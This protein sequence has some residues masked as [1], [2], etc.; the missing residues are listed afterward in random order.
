M[1]IRDSY[2]GSSCNFW[3]PYDGR[4]ELIGA[5]VHLLSKGLDS[6]PMLYHAL[7]APIELDCF[8]L[9]MKAVEV[10]H[11]SLVSRIKSGELMSYDGVEQDKN[12]EM[13]YTRNIDFNDDVAREYLGNML[14]PKQVYNLLANRYMSMFTNPFLS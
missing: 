14:T 8:T 9:G 7:P 6:G 4:P 10:A 1:C 5:T 11:D 12:L 3:A 13:R 2:R